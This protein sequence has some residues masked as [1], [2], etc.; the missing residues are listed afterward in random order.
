MVAAKTAYRS[1]VQKTEEVRKFNWNKIADNITSVGK[2]ENKRGETDNEMQESY[3]LPEKRQL[4]IQD[5][6]LF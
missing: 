3:I 6:T 2:Q 4:V 5:L 1:V